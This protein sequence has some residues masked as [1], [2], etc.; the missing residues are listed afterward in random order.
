MKKLIFIFLS[1]ITVLG[2]KTEKKEKKDEPIVKEV[3]VNQTIEPSVMRLKIN[4]KTNDS[5]ELQVVF[6]NIDLVNNQKGNY[7]VS[8]EIV[9]SDNFN[10]VSFEMF[11]DY[12]PNL[13]Q[14]KLK[15]NFVQNVEIEKIL[16]SYKDNHILIKGDEINK[17]FNANKY[18]D[19]EVENNLIKVKEIGGRALPI[20]TLKKKYINLLF[21][22]KIK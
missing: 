15:R 3:S 9:K 4:C 5:S 16:L 12:K 6:S 21:E 13:V 22:D 20:L 11:E 7:I 1:F 10:S 18:I 17:Y 14:I 2:C 8:Q 19:Y